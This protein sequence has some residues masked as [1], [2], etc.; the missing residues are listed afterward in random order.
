M[1]CCALVLRPD[2]HNRLFGLIF[3]AGQETN[4]Y[5]KTATPFFSLKDSYYD[6]QSEQWETLN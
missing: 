4:T 5:L 6:L 1:I 3:S 2:L